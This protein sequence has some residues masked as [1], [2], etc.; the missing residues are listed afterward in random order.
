MRKTYRRID[1]EAAQQ[2][3]ILERVARD[4]RLRFIFLLIIFNILLLIMTILS[5]RQGELKEERIILETRKIEYERQILEQVITET[6]VITV[7]I[8]GSPE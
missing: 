6:K 8:T 5:M 4:N 3:T 7:V 2:T 1:P